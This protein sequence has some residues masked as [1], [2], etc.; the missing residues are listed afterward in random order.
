MEPATE[1]RKLHR[2]IPQLRGMVINAHTWVEVSGR[3]VGKTSGMFAPRLSHNAFKMQRSLGAIVV[4]S[5]RTFLTQFI[6]SLITGLEELGYLEGKD[7]FIGKR[8]PAEWDRPI[9]SPQEWYHAMHFRC[10]SGAAFISQDGKA[11]GP[12]LSVQYMCLDEARKLDGDRLDNETFQTMRG[13]RQQFHTFSEYGS[14][15]IATDRP[16][17]TDGNW[18]ERYRERMDP[19]RIQ[20]ILQLEYERM[21]K[22]RAIES[23]TLS[24]AS[25]PVYRSTVLQQELMLNELRKTA[26]YFNES[27]TLENIHALGID[28]LRDMKQSMSDPMFR[29]TVLNEAIDHVESGFYPDLDEEKHTYEPAVTSYTLGLGYDRE[30]LS[31]RDCRHDAE[32]SHALPLDVAM[33]NGQ[34]INCLVVGQQFADEYRVDNA[35]HVT[36][37]GKCKDVVQAT[38]DYYRHRQCKVVNYYFDHTAIGHDGKSDY[39]YMDITIST[40]RQNGWEVR[41]VYIGHVP[42]PHIRYEMWGLLLNSARRPASMPSVRF[43]R[44]NCKNLLTSLRLAGAVQGEQGFKKDKS[45]ERDINADQSHTTHY[46]DACDILLSGRLHQSGVSSDDIGISV[47]S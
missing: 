19:D 33:D 28:R 30:K 5:Y 9:M 41:P 13:A 16:R 10:G 35:L 40:F 15:F 32:L 7:Y 12:G 27:S 14:L 29:I 20:L 43:N 21:K 17:T 31:A 34:S 45:A 23:G 22:M 18:I 42:K 3:G 37:P 2:N 1:T 38:C 26:V 36:Q 6:P 24:P 8:G 39:S 44:V 46:S 47:F 11:S 4:P 25:I